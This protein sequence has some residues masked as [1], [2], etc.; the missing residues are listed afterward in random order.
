MSLTPPDGCPKEPCQAGLGGLTKDRQEELPFGVARWG[1]VAAHNPRVDVRPSLLLGMVAV[2]WLGTRGQT[3][4][5]CCMCPGAYGG[6]NRKPKLKPMV[7]EDQGMACWVY[8]KASRLVT[9]GMV[10]HAWVALSK[11]WK[12]RISKEQDPKNVFHCY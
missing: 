9:G 10:L 5:L 2:L 7:L 11:M 1:P 12:E 3:L 4:P 6:L 8:I